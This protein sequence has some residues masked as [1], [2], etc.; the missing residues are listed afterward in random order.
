VSA[1]TIYCDG[2]AH[3]RPA[4]PGG[5]AF[6]VVENDVI[7]LSESGGDK[8]TNNNEM[9]LEAARLALRA[10]IERAWHLGREVELIS[11]SRL[12]VDIATGTEPPPRVHASQGAEVRQL[13]LSARVHAK[14]VR[15]HAGNRWNEHV[16]A[17]ASAAKTEL[18][19]VRFR[20]PT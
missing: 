5:W 15:S 7:L 2:S 13:C 14:W 19:P 11:D 10:V 6:V 16:D 12:V 9:E 1:L 20:P 3:E 4:R 18:V 17:M 8:S